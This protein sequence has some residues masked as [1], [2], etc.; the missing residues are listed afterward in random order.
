MVRHER[1]EGQLATAPEACAQCGRTDAR[2]TLTSRGQWCPSCRAA[3]HRE[4]AAADEAP[5][6]WR[7]LR[8]TDLTGAQFVTAVAWGIVKGLGTWVVIGVIVA[9]MIEIIAHS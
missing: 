6:D 9:L 5:T 3:A 1:K 7:A 8:V 4:S 2:L